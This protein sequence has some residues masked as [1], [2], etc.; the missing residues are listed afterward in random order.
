MGVID[1]NARVKS[2]EEGA[3][4][5]GAALDQLD[6]ALTATDNLLE[7]SVSLRLISFNDEDLPE[8][9]TVKSGKSCY[10]EYVGN[11]YHGH[12]EVT[13]LTAN[14]YTTLVEIPTTLRPAS[15]VYAIGIGVDYTDGKI[16]RADASTDIHVKSETTAA[17]FDIWWF[18]NRLSTD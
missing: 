8:G 3:E 9:I 18:N 1:L 6:S 7:E 10:I 4:S 12:F 2:L 15:V 11:V 16:C 13:G 5:Q 17:S 14:L